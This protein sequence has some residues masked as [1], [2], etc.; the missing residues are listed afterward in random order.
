M[1]FIGFDTIPFVILPGVFL[2]LMVAE[3]AF[4]LR[5]RKYS[6]ARRLAVNLS[7]SALAFLAGTTIVNPVSSGVAA[8]TSNS[9]FGL[10]YLLPLPPIPRFVE[11]FLL[12]DLTF[13]YWHRLNH[14]VP[15]LWRFHN[16][17]HIDPDLDVSTSF[18]FHFVEIIYS[19]AFRA[20]QVIIIG[21]TPIQYLVYETAFQ[22]A[23]MFHHSNLRLPIWVERLVNKIFVTPRMH[24]IHHSNIKEETNSNY[25]VIF[26]FWD[27]FHKTLHLSI[28]QH[29]INIGVAGYQKPEDNR[30]PNLLMAPFFKQ[31]I[32]WR[33]P[34]G[35]SMETRGSKGIE[36]RSKLLK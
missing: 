12:M 10:I 22:C 34:D 30:L 29:I 13:Y 25:A 1:S 36:D 33:T 2:F 5:R 14:T 17:H 6:L 11:G 20:L 27:L 4:P 35:R 32:Y 7:I 15:I 24:G 9:L 28:R 26:R 8:R 19:S 23:T 18:R 3:N 21:V 31:K 16:V